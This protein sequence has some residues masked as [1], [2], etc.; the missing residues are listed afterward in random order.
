MQGVTFA[1]REDPPPVPRRFSQV[2]FH[3]GPPF[4]FRQ[5]FKVNPAPVRLLGV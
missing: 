5:S 4:K 3:E 2:N 1:H